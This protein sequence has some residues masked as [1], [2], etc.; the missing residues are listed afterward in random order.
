MIHK[1]TNYDNNTIT[2]TFTGRHIY[3]FIHY[4]SERKEVLEMI[5]KYLLVYHNNNDLKQIYKEEIINYK[6]GLEILSTIDKMMLQ[7]E[8][9]YIVKIDENSLRKHST[10]NWFNGLYLNQEGKQLMP[11]INIVEL[12]P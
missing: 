4:L 7:Q 3:C 11:P 2:F 8:V 9:V 6:H 1:D 5:D 10:L 12:E